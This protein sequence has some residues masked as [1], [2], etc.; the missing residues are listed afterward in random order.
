MSEN[1]IIIPETNNQPITVLY[2]LYDSMQILWEH[3]YGSGGEHR[4]VIPKEFRQGKVI[5]SVINGHVD[6]AS[7]VGDRFTANAALSARK[8]A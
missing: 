1:P 4:T 5:L 2:S 7:Q 8:T 3:I 6:V